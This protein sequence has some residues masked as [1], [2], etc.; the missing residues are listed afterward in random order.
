[1]ISYI[2]PPV[3]LASIAAATIAGGNALNTAFM[4][5]RLGVIIMILPFIFVM[6]PTL[7]L[8]GEWT[9][10]VHDCI[11]AVIA[12]WL[13]ASAFERWL[14]GVGEIGLPVRA[15]LLVAAGVLLY[16]GTFSDAIGLGIILLTYAYGLFVRRRARSVAR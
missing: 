13:M 12:I 6:H 5:M 14:Y 1:M 16:P 9:D 15:G 10:I 4:S 7:I 8:V 3:A 2:T 11:T